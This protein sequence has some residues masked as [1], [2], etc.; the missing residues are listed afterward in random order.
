MAAPGGEQWPLSKE[1]L[2]VR[3]TSRAFRCARSCLA[4]LVV[5]APAFA[6]AALTHRYSFNDGTARDSAGAAHGVAV[7]GPRIVPVSPPLMF[8][9]RAT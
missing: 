6:G 2:M 5:V 3:A 9:M 1:H 7:N 8:G 4:V